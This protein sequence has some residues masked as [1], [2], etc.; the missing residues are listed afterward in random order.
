MSQKNGES[1]G[2]EKGGVMDG[3]RGSAIGGK[4][5]MVKG[6]EKGGRVMGGKMEEY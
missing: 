3:K 5:G 1:Y 2:W 6:E 4:R